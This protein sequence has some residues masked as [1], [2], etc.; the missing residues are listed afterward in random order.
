MIISKRRE[1]SLRTYSVAN[2]VK[3]FFPDFIA[4]WKTSLE[5]DTLK[6]MAVRMF[7]LF[8]TVLSL[9]LLVLNSRRLHERHWQT[10]HPL[11]IFF[12]L[13]KIEKKKRFVTFWV[14]FSW[15]FWLVTYEGDTTNKRIHL[16]L[17]V[18]TDPILWRI[19]TTTI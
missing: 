11:V 5:K 12:F 19:L 6:L 7:M 9:L 16:F 13:K 3:Q 2:R 10:D 1:K 14:I 17:E 15:R 4:I 18:H 8:F